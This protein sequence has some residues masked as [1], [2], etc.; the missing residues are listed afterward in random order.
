MEVSNGMPLPF[1]LL[2]S[3][4]LT[5]LFEDLNR[6]KSVPRFNEK[7]EAIISLKKC[8][9]PSAE[10]IWS[11][12]ILSY[13]S[14]PGGGT[15]QDIREKV[16]AQ[17]TGKSWKAIKNFPD[18]LLALAEEIERL[19]A[20]V[21]FSPSQYVNRDT[22]E[23]AYFRERFMQLPGTLRI[24]A[25]GLRMQAGRVPKLTAHF[26]QPTP[27]GY[28]ESVFQLSE[29]VKAM[30]GQY[31]DREVADLLNAAAPQMER[32]ERFDELSLAQARSR[33][34]GNRSRS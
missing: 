6:L 31:H 15:I 10:D 1:A 23:V 2:G 13:V 26:L 28:P 17:K 14:V 20:S 8:R 25:A 12:L 7:L 24:Y 3:E 11:L 5:L 34:K 18:R 19:N 27:R 32:Q 29:L 21:Y 16:W 4:D 30:T 22:R 9:P 33:R